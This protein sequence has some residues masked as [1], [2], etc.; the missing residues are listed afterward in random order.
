MKVSIIGGCGFIGLSLYK[1]FSKQNI[2]VKIIDT[3]R[4][5]LK[6]KTKFKN[7][8]LVNYDNT[9]SLH[10][11]IKDTDILI[12]LYSG[13]SPLSSSLADKNKLNK[14]I[15]I[16]KSIFKIS[17]TVN[18]KKII[19]TSSGGTVYGNKKKFPIKENFGT[20]P[21]SNYGKVKLL[22]EREL[23]KNFTKN[24]YILRLSNLYGP[25]Q[26]KNSKVGLI[27]KLI[28]AI[29]KNNRFYIWG[30]GSIVR[31]YLFIEDLLLL[32]KTLITENIKS[33]IY[34]V[35]SSRGYSINQLI[36]K[37]D[38]ITKKKCKV[39]YVEKRNFDI[40][41]NVLCNKKIYKYSL[42][43]PIVKI[44]SGIKKMIKAYDS[45]FFC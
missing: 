2:K 38:K 39:E 4:R 28:E 15:K 45:N 6:T 16:N 43:K 3:K 30:S 18:V 37:I 40:S 20:M 11:A 19:F 31:D 24:F 26:F 36:T 17:K 35:S 1:Y 7:Y 22:S 41:K 23:K 5:F 29:K 9:K 14:E 27:T 12:N 34:N 32:I 42:W 8:C 33:G 10:Q 25:M 44:D 21:I 13:I